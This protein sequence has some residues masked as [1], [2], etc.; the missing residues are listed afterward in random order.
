MPKK[1]GIRRHRGASDAEAIY[2]PYPG[3]WDY[4]HT[5]PPETGYHGA[6]KKGCTCGAG[7]WIMF[8][9]KCG[10]WEKIEHVWDQLNGSSYGSAGRFYK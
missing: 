5:P 6:K 7:K 8:E 9:S 10:S 1:A 2:Y 3:N 4:L